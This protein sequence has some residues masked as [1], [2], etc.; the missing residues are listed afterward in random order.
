MSSFIIQDPTDRP[1]GQDYRRLIQSFPVMRV[2]ASLATQAHCPAC[3]LSHYCFV[4]LDGRGCRCRLGIDLLDDRRQPVGIQ[5]AMVG[6]L[7]T[8]CYS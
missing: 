5:Q 1:L 3:A 4:A 8:V 7:A 2:M 6:R